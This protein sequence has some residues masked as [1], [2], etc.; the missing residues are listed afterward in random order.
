MNPLNQDLTCRHIVLK[1]ERV[2]ED[3]PDGHLVVFCEGGSGCERRGAG[4]TIRGRALATNN[5]EEFES[6]L[7]ERLATP[8][9]IT[10][11]QLLASNKQS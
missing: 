9:E 5:V 8:E 3:I 11:A 10:H 7:V 6:E 2:P 1:R 4:S